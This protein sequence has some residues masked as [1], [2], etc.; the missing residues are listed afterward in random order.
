MRDTLL[1]VT[2][3]RNDAT[4]SSKPAIHASF[5]VAPCVSLHRDRD[6]ARRRAQHRA[7]NESA[8]NAHRKERFGADFRPV[9]PP[10]EKEHER[11]TKP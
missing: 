4:I 3:Q 9:N 1:I 5:S 6:A 10:E 11:P 7:R 8:A 2:R